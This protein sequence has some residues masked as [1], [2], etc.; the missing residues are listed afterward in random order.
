M[1]S[2][3]VDCTSTLASG[4][5]LTNKFGWGNHTGS[6]VFVSAG[7]RPPVLVPADSKRDADKLVQFVHKSSEA[8]LLTA[9][10]DGRALSTCFMSRVCVVVGLPGSSA[11]TGETAVLLAATARRH[12]NAALL[13]VD[14]DELRLDPLPPLLRPWDP[15]ARDL[16]SQGEA[17]D[18]DSLVSKEDDVSQEIHKPTRTPPVVL[19]L[20]RDRSGSLSAALAVLGSDPATSLTHDLIDAVIARSAQGSPAEG[21]TD[22]GMFV[23]TLA[24]DD[25]GLKRNTVATASARRVRK[26]PKAT[27]KEDGDGR[28]TAQAE[29]RRRRQ[30]REREERERMAKEEAEAVAQAEEP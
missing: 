22:D 30:Q 4:K 18:I 23:A 27:P 13:L 10:A 19:A 9:G 17:P 3:T 2:Y 21:A 7:G 28:T 14:V 12:K 26:T 5:S 11:A 16:L 20:R 8:P 24:K 15:A 29:R 6:I 1:Q 25:V